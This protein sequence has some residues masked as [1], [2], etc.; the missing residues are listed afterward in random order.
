MKANELLVGQKFRIGKT[1]ATLVCRDSDN[2]LEV[3][4]GDRI[5]FLTDHDLDAI[6]FDLIVPAP[7]PCPFCGCDNSKTRGGGLS[8]F[9]RKCHRCGAEGPVRDTVDEAD[10]S[11]NARPEV[12]S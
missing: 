12:Q 6:G 4:I 5:H 9:V 7:Q 8:G 1:E 2:L 10:R 3:R 11:W